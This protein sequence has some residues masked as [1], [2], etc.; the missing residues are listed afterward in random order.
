MRLLIV[1]LI[2]SFILS[3][4]GCAFAPYPDAGDLM[5]Y[6]PDWS[7]AVLKKIA[8]RTGYIGPGWTPEQVECS[9][10]VYS[11]LSRVGHHYHDLPDLFQVTL[12][13]QELRHYTVYRSIVTVVFQ[14]RKVI[15]VVALDGL[16]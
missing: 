4:M 5:D 11:G 13:G 12:D 3:V 14:D 10:G 16:N 1:L 9:L 2:P 6:H 8:A 7:P 15:N